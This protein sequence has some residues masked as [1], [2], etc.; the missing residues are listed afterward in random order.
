M[1]IRSPYSSC[2]ICGHQCVRNFIQLECPLCNG[3]AEKAK[4]IKTWEQIQEE[5][6]ARLYA[7]C[8]LAKQMITFLR[9][10]GINPFEDEAKK[11]GL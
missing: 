9:E 7:V 10:A 6:I 4:Q 11:L 5:E 2:D 8:V 3:D 1:S